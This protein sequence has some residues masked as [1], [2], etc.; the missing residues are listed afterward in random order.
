MCTNGVYSYKD[1]NLAHRSSPKTSAHEKNCVAHPSSVLHSGFV[2]N[3]RSDN[4]RGPH[5]RPPSTHFKFD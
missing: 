5:L 4:Y 3:K 2:K 1:S